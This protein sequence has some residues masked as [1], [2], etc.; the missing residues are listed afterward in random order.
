MDE[1]RIGRQTPTQSV[2]LP[3]T[4]TEG[5]AAVKLYN[6]TG[7]KAQEWQELLLFDILG[8]RDDGLWTHTKFGF[9]VP[10]RNG[11]N[12]VVAMRELYAMQKGETVLHTADF[13]QPQRMGTVGKPALCSGDRT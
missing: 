5:A 8:K 11:K 2:T 3:Y 9:A 12:E 13:H 6:S 4:V 7:N 1:K 10:R